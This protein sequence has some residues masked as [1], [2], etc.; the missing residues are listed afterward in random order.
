MH[1]SL[2]TALFASLLTATTAFGA[3]MPDAGKLIKESTP[4]PVLSPEQTPPPLPNPVQP[5]TGQAPDETRVKVWGF[6]FT[7]NTLF[8]QNELSRLMASSLGKEMTLG[9]L[10][11]AA[12]AITKAYRKKGYFL[13]SL[14]FPPQTIKPGSP[15]TIEIVEGNLETIEVKTTPERTRTPKRIFQHYALEAPLGKPVNDATLTS[16]VMKTNELPNITSRILLEPGERPGT[17]KATLEVTEGKPSAFLIDADNYG[18]QATGNYYFGGTLYLYSPLHQGEQCTLRLK[19]STTGDLQNGRASY[20]V[21][22]TAYGTKIG[23]DY[24]YVNYRLGGLFKPLHASGNAQSLD[25]T[26]SQPLVRQRNLILSATLA[27]EGRELDDR[28]EALPNKQRHTRSWQAALAGMESDSVLGSG[29]TSFSIGFIGGTLGIDDAETRLAD[30]SSTGLNTSGSYN[31][32]N[33]SLG[34]TEILYSR[35]SFY[36]G[37]YGQWANKNL[38][39]SE[40]LSL[41]GPGAVRAWQQDDSYAD[42]GIIAT[43]E[44]R[45]LF[46][47]IG[48]LPGKVQGVV[49]V[50]HG[51]GVLHTNPL[52]GSG[53][54]ALHLTGAGIGV[55]W[56]NAHNYSLQATCAWKVSGKTLPVESPMVF[57]QAVKQL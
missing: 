41:G 49:F 56:F 47:S 53:E 44:L 57:V 55:N 52:P 26:L 36:A 1:T 9:E 17:T 50:D 2:K 10:N 33:L 38:N 30:Q 31:K 35:L 5:K 3:E 27:G 37:A 21:P 28:M 24:S 13:A 25:I 11:G 14:F 16:M 18:N 42:K 45:Y 12:D 8:S 19:T 23:V 51:Y 4:P 40:Q 54:N 15:I 32:L 22:V 20:L 48:E 43:A 46:D 6:T 39:S 34:R 7:G 29:S